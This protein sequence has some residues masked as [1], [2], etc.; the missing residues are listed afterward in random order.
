MGLYDNLCNKGMG[1]P[2][3]ETGKGVELREKKKR[4]YASPNLN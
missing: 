1:V 2:E 4:S 3:T